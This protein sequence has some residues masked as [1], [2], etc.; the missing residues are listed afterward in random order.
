[1]RPGAAI[2]PRVGLSAVLPPGAPISIGQPLAVV[3]AAD[4]GSARAAGQAVLAAM[5]IADEA[6]AVTAVVLQ[7]LRG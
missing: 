4:A 5:P 2:D 6:P 1:T 7:T 3:H